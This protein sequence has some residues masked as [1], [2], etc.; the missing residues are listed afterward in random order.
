M[1]ESPRTPSGGE[2]EKLVRSL[3]KIRAS[4]D[5]PLDALDEFRAAYLA[6]PRDVR[7][8]FFSL[9]LVRMEV[10]RE[11]VETPLRSVLEA[12][13]GDP[14]EWTSL[15]TDLRR[16]LESPRMRVFRRFLNVSGGLKFLLDLRADV[17]AAERQSELDLAPID[18]EISY[19][20]K[21]VVPVR[22]PI[23][24]GDHARLFLP[25][26]PLPQGAR[27]GASHG[28]ARGDGESA[29]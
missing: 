8:S 26:D 24:A 13:S 17:L 1:N 7:E 27:H 10:S 16:T 23:P 29:R 18:E 15:L 14:V 11:A 12:P 25:A 19:L 21:L 4:A 6:A 3:A 28:E 2:A 20:F 9:L 5:L 22:L